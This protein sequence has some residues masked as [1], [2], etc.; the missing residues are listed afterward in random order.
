MTA[1]ARGSLKSTCAVCAKVF[2][3]AP[4]K[5]AR[6]CGV[7][8]SATCRAEVTGFGRQIR[9]A[10]P[11]TARQI[12]EKSRVEV[13]C[14]RDRLGDM[15]R[16]GTCHVAGFVPNDLGNIQGAPKFMPVLALGPSPDPDMPADMRAAVTYHTRRIILAAMPATVPKIAEATGMPQTST[17]RIVKALYDEGKC[18][19]GGWQRA[20]RGLAAAIYHAGEGQDQPCRLKKFTPA[21]KD[22]RHRRKLKTD[23]ALSEKYEAKMAKDRS[24]YWDKKATTR[25]DPMIAAVFGP[26]RHLSEVI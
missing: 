7:T 6:G 3:V 18:H 4:S 16:A 17:L 2:T 8:C 13:A 14:V 24:R 22:K 26:A 23:P 12:A 11:G 1:P 19:E 9:A 21:Q 25:R 15:L 5:V 10:M 20:A